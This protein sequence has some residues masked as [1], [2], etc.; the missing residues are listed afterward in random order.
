M[1]IRYAV[2]AAVVAAMPSV[3]YGQDARLEPLRHGDRF[4]EANAGYSWYSPRGGGW[5]LITGRRVYLTALRAEW[6]VNSGPHVAWG[7]VVEWTPLAV[8]QRVS[9]AET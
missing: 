3:A 5:G 6:V 2:I 8:V 7:Y 1:Q 4:F 9:R